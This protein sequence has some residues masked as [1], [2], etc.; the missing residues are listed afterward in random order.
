MTK[1]KIKIDRAK[2]KDIKFCTECLNSMLDEGVFL[3]K[4]EGTIEQQ[5]IGNL[6]NM[7][8][9]ITEGIRLEK[10]EETIT[11]VHVLKASSK[12]IGFLVSTSSIGGV[13]EI[14]LAYLRK[15]YRGRGLMELYLKEYLTNIDTI[16]KRK[17]NVYPS[18]Y[19]RVGSNSPKMLYLSVL[20]CNFE[21]LGKG[22]NYYQLF[23]FPRDED[24]KEYREGQIN[25]FKEEGLPEIYTKEESLILIKKLY[26]KKVKT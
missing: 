12:K 13:I 24:I 10:V 2:E 6:L 25:I 11:F 20:K 1:P 26:D 19:M 22:E 9:M 16:I 15:E 18:Y 5:K 3:G 8:S 14:Y 4:H 21:L 7:I 17:Y 23:L